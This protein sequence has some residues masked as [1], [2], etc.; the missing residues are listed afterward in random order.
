MRFLLSCS[1]QQADDLAVI[2]HE[3]GLRPDSGGVGLHHGGNGVIRDIEFLEGMQVSLLTERRSRAPY[4]LN[5]G[6]EGRVGVNTWL[7][8]SDGVVR[9]KVN[10]GGKA[11][12]KVTAGDRLVLHTPGGGAWGA[13]ERRNE[14]GAVKTKSGHA[15]EPRGS[16]AE[17][18]SAEAAFGA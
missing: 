12:I 5:G 3:F 14:A 6:G 4:G 1:N 2:L 18:A 15:W 13:G 7:K 17:K 16:L 10:L 9:R 8:Q 11:S